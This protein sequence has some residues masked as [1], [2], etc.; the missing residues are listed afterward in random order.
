[1]YPRT[2]YEMTEADLEKILDACKPTVAIMIGGYAGNTPQ[3]NANAAW[4]E[5]GQRM[6]FDSMTVEPIPGKGNRFFSAVPTENETQRQEREA[7]EAADKKR[8]RIKQLN[9]YIAI[10]QAELETLNQ[11]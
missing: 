4:A 6:G 1:M 3:D 9:D 8:E 11:S 2:N 5:L 7:R 10:M